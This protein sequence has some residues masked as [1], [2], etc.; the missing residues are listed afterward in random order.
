MIEATDFSIETLECKFTVESRLGL[1][2]DFAKN[3]GGSTSHKRV[4][5]EGCMSKDLY[6][7]LIDA[8]SAVMQ[9]DRPACDPS[10][11]NDQESA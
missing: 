8:M 5:F 10:L 4:S 3:T 9:D 6:A 2:G 7:A 11:E 1:G